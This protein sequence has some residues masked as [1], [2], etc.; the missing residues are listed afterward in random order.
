MAIE[1][2][3]YILRLVRRANRSGRPGVGLADDLTHLPAAA[4]QDGEARV[5][6]VIAA[7]AGPI[8]CDL[9]RAAHLAPDHDRDILV[10]A[11]FVQV[12]HQGR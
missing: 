10:Q 8:L 11:P 9:G 6:P 5:M 4:G 1:G 3:Q 12:A 7:A 2:R